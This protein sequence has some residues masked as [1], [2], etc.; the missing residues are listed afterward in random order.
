MHAIRFSLKQK[1]DILCLINRR[2]KGE[3]TM[4]VIWF[5]SLMAV[6]LLLVSVPVHASEM[7]KR[8]ES[9]ARDSYVFKTYLK[10]DDVQVRSQDGVVVLTGTVAEESHKTLAQDT[11]AGLPG[12]KSVDNKLQVKG[13]TPAL[14]SDAWLSAKVKATLLLHKNVSAVKT[15]VSAANGIVTLLGGQIAGAE[16]SAKRI[17]VIAAALHAGFTI[18]DMINLDLGYAPPFSPVWDPVQIAARVAA[19]RV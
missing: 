12:V 9:S 11:V 18:E 6:A 15:K 14:N 17:D 5:A 2:Q 13:E 8:I 3:D 19:K 7:D 1:M 4:K 16:G 10:G